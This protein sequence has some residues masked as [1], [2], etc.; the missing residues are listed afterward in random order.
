MLGHRGVVT[1]VELPAGVAVGVGERYEEVCMGRDAVLNV[2][3]VV[4]FVVGTLD[5]GILIVGVLE[6]VSV[7]D[8]GPVGL[9]VM[10]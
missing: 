4:A 5:T 9:I 2:A 6:L 10:L 7:I 1:E 8:V 3:L